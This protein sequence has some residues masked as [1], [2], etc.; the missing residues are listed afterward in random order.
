MTL[1]FLIGF[2]YFA[3][4]LTYVFM[5]ELY[6]DYIALVLTKGFK[7]Y[8]KFITITVFILLILCSIVFWPL[9]IALLVYK[10]IKNAYS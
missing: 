5:N 1:Y 7:S 2:V 8:G 10:K 9:E 6:R 4:A 3:I